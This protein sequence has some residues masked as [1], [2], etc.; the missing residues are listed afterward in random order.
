MLSQQEENVI[1]SA[2]NEILD[3]L[4]MLNP[5][6]VADFLVEN[7][8]VLAGRLSDAI[9]FTFLDKDMKDGLDTTQG[10]DF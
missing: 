5:Q 7:D 10:I 1:F 8:P 4:E 6:D 2:L 9:N 3:S